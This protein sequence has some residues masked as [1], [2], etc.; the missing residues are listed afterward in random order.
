VPGE[1]DT[2][3]ADLADLFGELLGHQVT[4]LD[5][6]FFE[7]GGHSILAIQLLARVRER[8]GTEVSIA[9]FMSAA[10]D[11]TGST[12]A[13][14][15]GLAH[16]I[17]QGPRREPARVIRLR[18]GE[19]GT[20]LVLLHPAGGEISL[21]REL[22]AALEADCDIYAVQS[23]L[24][25]P[26]A[27]ADLVA[28]YRKHLAATAGH[29][30]F[31]VLGWSFGG[32]L[33][34]ELACQA[35]AAGEPI[36]SLVVLDGY[37]AQAGR[38]GSRS[39]GELIAEVAQT[40]GVPV[41]STGRGAT[42]GVDDAARQIAGQLDVPLDLVRQRLELYLAD[43]RCWYEHTPRVYPGDM[44]LVQAAVDAPSPLDAELSLWQR[45][46]EGSM[47]VRRVAATHHELLEAPHAR[48]LASW[49]DALAPARA[50]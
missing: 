14:I 43:L 49:I 19:T 15:S 48:E 9:E 11:R 3:E 28:E 45:I 17:R 23:S 25:R 26:R 24:A 44:L 47:D 2:L 34:H 39:E 31:H 29:R 10:E 6:D 7:E 4:R 22:W 8:F 33:A 1:S 50:G 12:V 30:A 5:V 18:G 35:V 16:T 37:P 20:P 13:S 36:G 27:L 21:Y 46:C 42:L 32:I 40:F 41:T 38:T